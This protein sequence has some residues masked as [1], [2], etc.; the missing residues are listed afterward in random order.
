LSPSTSPTIRVVT[1]PIAAIGVV[2]AAIR[3][4]IATTIAAIG[5]TIAATIAAAIGIVTAA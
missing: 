1:A 3:V 2:T 4:T 5:V